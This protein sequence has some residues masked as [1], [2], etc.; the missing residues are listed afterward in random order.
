MCNRKVAL[1][2]VTCLA[3]I[4]LG[5]GVAIVGAAN[6]VTPQ[7]A[8]SFSRKIAIISAQS[9]MATR[10]AAVRRTPVSEDEVN[11]W[12]A[13]RAQS[14]LPQGMTE[15]QLTIIGN[16]KVSATATVDLD[17]VARQKRNGA[18]LNPWN[19]VGGRVPVTVSGVLS[20]GNG[21]GQFDLEEATLSGIPVP[22]SLLQELV[23]Y[24]SRSDTQ[25]QGIRID[26]PFALPANIRQ[27]EVGQGQAIV[28]Q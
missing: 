7:Q 8:D 12:F 17:T 9:T 23:S 21:R 28:I 26:D 16:G 1:T 10:V 15:P 24:Y 5:L 14:L 20:T 6:R 18:V 11:S 3:S 13:Y 2:A 27:I 25:P 19:L 4:A 22:R